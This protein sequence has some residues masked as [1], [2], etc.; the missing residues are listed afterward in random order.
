VYAK[1]VQKQR[2]NTNLGYKMVRIKTGVVPADPS[3]GVKAFTYYTFTIVAQKATNP[4]E[5]VRMDLVQ[6]F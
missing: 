2:G 4:E 6:T 3:M 5:R 1:I